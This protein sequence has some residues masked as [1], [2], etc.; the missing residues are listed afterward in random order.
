VTPVQYQAPIQTAPV[1]Y[2][3]PVQAGPVQAPTGGALVIYAV[4]PLEGQPG[5]LLVRGDGFGTQAGQVMLD[6]N[7]VRMG[8]QVTSWIPNAL[9]V[10]M[11]GL[12]AAP[13]A[14]VSFS[15]QRAD[16]ATSQPFNPASTA[17][18]ASR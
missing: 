17:V 4:E 18:V 15:V 16:G 12:Q 13:G 8:L 14:A 7:G 11:P 3:A 1:Q 6:I 9:V 10:K 2:Q 5:H